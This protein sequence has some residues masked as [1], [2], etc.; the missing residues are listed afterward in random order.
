MH[1]QMQTQ[2]ILKIILIAINN[3]TQKKDNLEQ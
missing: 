3:F 2:T 1:T